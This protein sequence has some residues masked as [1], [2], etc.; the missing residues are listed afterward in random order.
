MLKFC[1]AAVVDTVLWRRI[2]YRRP[3]SAPVRLEGSS[4]PGVEDSGGAWREISEHGV[5]T[6][7]FEA[8]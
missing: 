8:E 3:S 6:C 2:D 1:S 4:S 5:G 7:P